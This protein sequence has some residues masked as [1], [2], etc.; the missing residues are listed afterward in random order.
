MHQSEYDVRWPPTLGLTRGRDA[1]AEWLRVQSWGTVL[2]VLAYF[3]WM[4]R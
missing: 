4:R 2:T 3:V 1:D